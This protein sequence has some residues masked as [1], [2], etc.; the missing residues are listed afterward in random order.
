MRYLELGMVPSKRHA[1]VGGNGSLLVEEVMGYEGFS[2]NE[3][4]LY[5]LH[6]PCRIDSVGALTP[7]VRPT[8]TPDAHVHRLADMRELP[9]GGD[10]LSGRQLIMFNADL[11][12][13][14]AKPTAMRDGFYRNGQGDEVIYV[15]RGRGTLRTIFGRVAFCERDY[16]VIPRGTTHTWE[17]DPDVEQ[18]WLC[19]HTPG[20]LETPQRYRNRYGQLLEHA[21]FSQ[22]DVHGPRD[23]ETRDESGSYRL[24]VRVPGVCR[25]TCWTAIRS[26]SSAGM[27][28]SGRTRSTPMTSSHGRAGFTCRRRRT[29]PSRARTS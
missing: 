27:A 22:R 6:S 5:H 18:F 13:S 16:V 24:T 14:V 8:W 1:Q 20:E 3:S 19:F 29:R 25:T 15:H 4:I 7:I 26:M 12:V 23:L 28:T 9:S 2:G 21:P 17:L 11:E 10:P